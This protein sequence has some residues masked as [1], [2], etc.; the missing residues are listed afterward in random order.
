MVTDIVDS[1][2]SAVVLGDRRWRDIRNAHHAVIR[3]QLDRFE[4]TEVDTS[5]D[6]FLATFE[7]PVDA[8]RCACAISDQ[9]RSLGI[10]V[11]I[12][13]HAD[14]TER[15]VQDLDFLY[16]VTANRVSSLATGGE[17]LISGSMKELLLGADV[18]LTSRGEHALAGVPGTVEIYEVCR[19]EHERPVKQALF[20]ETSTLDPRALNQR[21][22]LTLM[23]TDILGA[24]ALAATVGEAAWREIRDAHDRIVV[25]E[26]ER[27]G[28]DLVDAAGDQF[29]VTF[30]GPAQAVICA[31][32]IKDGVKTLGIDVRIGLHTGE[33]EDM[34]DKV[35]GIAV[36][37]G[38]R[39]MSVAGPGEILVSSTVKDLLEGSGLAFTEAGQHDL[40][41]VPGSRSVF[42]LS[43][44]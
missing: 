3:Q 7:R 17:V 19:D 41:G 1:T 39:V 20:A 6:G 21:S 9:V 11:R 36:H 4:G 23:F 2:R 12:G 44:W 24:A 29:F 32:A 30:G 18:V 15:P 27:A 5:G 26:V 35:G 25:D 40:K 10:D 16:L 28:G 22:V 31:C 42:S 13:M 34:G 14:R 37:V 38:A 33:V 43:G 8:V